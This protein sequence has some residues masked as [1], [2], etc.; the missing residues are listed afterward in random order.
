MFKINKMLA[1][2]GLGIGREHH[3]PDDKL[4]TGEILE[5]TD[6]TIVDCRNLRDDRRN[7]LSLYE[8]KILEANS[9]IEKHGKIVCCCEHGESRSNAI[10][11]GVLITHFSMDYVSA[12]E[13]ITEKVPIVR[14]KPRHLA[15]LKKL[16]NVGN[17]FE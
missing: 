6:F 4:R 9:M 17:G 5:G 13:L 7:P 11:A 16:F 2:H 14:I 8:N 1:T 12:M 10:A 15:A 3:L